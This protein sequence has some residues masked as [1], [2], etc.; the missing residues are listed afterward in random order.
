MITKTPAN[1]SPLAAYNQT[2]TMLIERVVPRADEVTA[3]EIVSSGDVFQAMQVAMS[4]AK[5]NTGDVIIVMYT[6]AAEEER[7]L[8][9]K[10]IDWR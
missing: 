6:N 8:S 9:I 2:Y 5:P 4:L 1:L 10:V 3:T 7:E